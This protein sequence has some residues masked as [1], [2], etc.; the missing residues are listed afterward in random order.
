MRK[1]S[2]ELTHMQRPIHS[3]IR[4]FTIIELLVVIG[5]IAV[6]AGLLIPA[7]TSARQKAYIASTKATM[8][9]IEGAISTFRLAND[10]Q[11][12]LDN[13]SLGIMDTGRENHTNFI[14]ALATVDSDSFG[15]NGSKLSNGIIVDGWAQQIRYR[16][17]IAYPNGGY[18]DINPDSYQ[19]WSIGP[20]GE[21]QVI[22]ADNPSLTSDDITNWGAR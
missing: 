5:I 8:A 14:D 7:V 22:S 17:F 12:P 15:N 21:D 3:G 16:P 10:G 2:K 19:L 11:L 18:Y 1:N 6:L 9:T 20:D 13:G 4:G